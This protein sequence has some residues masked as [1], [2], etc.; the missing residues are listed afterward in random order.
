MDIATVMAITTMSLKNRPMTW[1]TLTKISIGT[2]RSASSSTKNIKEKIKLM[3]S[4]MGMVIV[5]GIAQEKNMG[6]L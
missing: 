2:S 4:I 3:Q 1:R 5:T 6:P